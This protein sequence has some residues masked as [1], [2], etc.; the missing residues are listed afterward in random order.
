MNAAAVGPS[1]TFA[2]ASHGWA[3]RRGPRHHQADAAASY[4]SAA[5][6]LAVAVVDGV[7]DSEAA[8]FAARLVADHAVRVAALEGRPD[9]AVLAAHDLLTSTRDLVPGDAAAVVALA[10]GADDPRW[11]LAWVGDCRA[12]AWDGRALRTLTADHT[13]AAALRS[14]GLHVHPRL[15]HVL[16]VSVR[17]ARP[18][19]VGVVVVDDPGTLLLVSDGVHRSVAGWTLAAVLAGSGSAAE[20]AERIVGLAAAAGATDNATALVL[21]PSAGA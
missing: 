13:V 18:Q 16:T 4:R 8:G 15:E 10:P 2:D 9:L 6:R 3:S 1:S 11:R 7:G 20:Q 12:L 14:R 17:T 21:S 19:E 5:G